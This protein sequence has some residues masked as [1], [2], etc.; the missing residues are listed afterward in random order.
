MKKPPLLIKLSV[1]LLLFTNTD[2]FAFGTD[3]WFNDTEQYS[4]TVLS[5]QTS[6]YQ[7]TLHPL[8]ENTS[9]IF[10]RPITRP[11][12]NSNMSN[13]SLSRS[14]SYQG[15][16]PTMNVAPFPSSVFKNG[17]WTSSY[18]KALTRNS[19]NLV[20]RQPDLFVNYTEQ[21]PFASASP[22]MMQKVPPF[23]GDPGQMPVGDGVWILLTAAM[24]YFIYKKKH[25][26]TR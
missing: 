26:L 13:T 20:S 14:L 6:P 12:Y 25:I 23:P 7:A 3:D 18:S 15:L 17:K 19:F 1:A 2:I 22:S 11:I 21:T 4:Y 10:E 5:Q 9:T 16:E 24:G 8:F